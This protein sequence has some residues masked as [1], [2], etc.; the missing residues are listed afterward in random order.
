MP[1]FPGRL[2]LPSWIGKPTL[3]KKQPQISITTGMHLQ[4]SLLK[5][6]FRGA[7][8]NYC[9]GKVQLWELFSLFWASSVGIK[10]MWAPA[11]IRQ[12]TLSRGVTARKKKSR[13][14]FQGG[15]AQCWLFFST[16]EVSS[17]VTPV[18]SLANFFLYLSFFDMQC[19]LIEGFHPRMLTS[20]FVLIRLRSVI[21]APVLSVILL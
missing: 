18:A 14:Q 12:K 6:W 13:D 11:R 21:S 4:P 20:A 15:L 9:N 8:L 10:R 5:T 1:L 17:K 3:V 16:K 7:N 2:H 19:F